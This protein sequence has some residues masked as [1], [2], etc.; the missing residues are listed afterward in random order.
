MLKISKEQSNSSD[1]ISKDLYA[2][3][4]GALNQ[5]QN[6]PVLGPSRPVAHEEDNLDNDGISG[7]PHALTDRQL[8]QNLTLPLVPNLNIPPSPPGTPSSTCT[9]KFEKFL[10]LKKQGVHF[11]AKISSLSTLR[12]PSLLPNLLKYAGINEEPG[13]YASTLPSELAPMPEGGF[14]SSAYVEQL[15]KSQQDIT[16]R[17]EGERIAARRPP[18]FVTAS[19][20]NATEPRKKQR[21]D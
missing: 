2:A 12:N 21:L 4:G 1:G 7:G 11:N 8:I 19:Q 14:P 3:S 15:A 9:D 17:K 13:Q 20:G 5:A 18:E 10:E 6:G 16:K